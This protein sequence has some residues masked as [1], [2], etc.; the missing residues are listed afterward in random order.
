MESFL[1]QTNMSLNEA[2]WVELLD[3][4][5]L[6]TELP[7]V[8][9][10]DNVKSLG[11]YHIAHNELNGIKLQLWK[12]CLLIPY[13]IGSVEYIVVIKWSKIGF[14]KFCDKLK[15]C[16]NLYR[17]IGV[18]LDVQDLLCIVPQKKNPRK[19]QIKKHGH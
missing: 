3:E 1:V 19:S 9:V 15:R 10:E 14:V 18:T 7:T 4:I 13:V 8:A 12:M 2:S 11:N 17:W 16:W 6:D 5:D